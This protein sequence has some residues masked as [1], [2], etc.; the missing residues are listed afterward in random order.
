MSP[1]MTRF[2]P[3]YAIAL[4]FAAILALVI[5]CQKK[6]ALERRRKQT[7][8]IPVSRTVERDVTDYADYTGR[9]DAVQAV[10][11]R[12]RATGYLLSAR[13]DEGAEVQ[14][15]DLLFE[16]DPRP[17]QFLVDQAEA[18]VKSAEAALV[19]AKATVEADKQGVRI[20]GLGGVIS[21]LQIITDEQNV[22]SSQAKLNSAN[23]TLDTAKENLSYT[24]VKAQISGQISRYYYTPGNLI[25]QDQTLLTTIISTKYMYAYFDIEER[26]RDKIVRTISNDKRINTLMSLDQR[27]IRAVA[28]G[29]GWLTPLQQANFPVT[30]V[31]EGQTDLPFRGVLDFINNQVNPST[32]TVAARGFFK[33]TQL[34]L[35]AW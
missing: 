19:T 6:T 17:Y 27:A 11:V 2:R 13:F 20:A 7:R 8:F 28:G 26:V 23:S 33:N 34:Q 1:R 29:M 16:I 12:A 9:T 25:T 30:M 21:S 22:I 4:F 5:G 10:N 3:L 15:G 14:E 32:G 31:I 35:A 18:S 24:K